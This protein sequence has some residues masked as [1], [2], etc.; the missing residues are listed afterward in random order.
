MKPNCNTAIALPVQQGM[1]DGS[2]AHLLVDANGQVIA[3]LFGIEIGLT[4]EQARKSKL[5]AKGMLV[6]ECLI[7]AMNSRKE[8]VDALKQVSAT[9]RQ[10]RL[11]RISKDALIAAGELKE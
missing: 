3:N 4:V 9:S 5:S 8:M 1:S 7:T 6:A 2:N 10:Q 11:A